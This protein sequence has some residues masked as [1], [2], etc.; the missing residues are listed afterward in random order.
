M[1]WDKPVH[2]VQSL[3]KIEVVEDSDDEFMEEEEQEPTFF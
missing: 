2:P 1:C 3:P